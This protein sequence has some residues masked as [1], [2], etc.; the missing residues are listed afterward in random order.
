MHGI[1]RRKGE[2]LAGY[3]AGF[4]AG[5]RVVAHAVDVSRPADVAAAVGAAFEPPESLS[6]CRRCHRFCREPT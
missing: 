5:G 2:M 3:D 6:R 1:A 4:L